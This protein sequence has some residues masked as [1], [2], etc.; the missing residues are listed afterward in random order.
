[1]SSKLTD[2]LNDDLKKALVKRV[3]NAEMD[4]HLVGEDP[5]NRRNGYGKKAVITDPGQVELAVSR[6]R[7]ASFSAAFREPP[8]AALNDIYRAI[9]AV[10]GALISPSMT[11]SASGNT[12]QSARAGGVP[13][14][15][16]VPFYTFPA[17]VRRILYD[18]GQRGAHVGFP[19]ATTRLVA[20]P[21]LVG[22]R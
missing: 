20:V 11:V 17:D 14:V 22:I 5:D 7:P 21:C 6:D 13:G 4:H 10:A 19:H 18:C 12:R 9:D 15:K 2:W 16:I 3:L 1:M 8:A